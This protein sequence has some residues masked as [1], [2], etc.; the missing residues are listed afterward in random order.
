MK[1]QSIRPWSLLACG[2]LLVLAAC[3]Q[4]LPAEKQAYAG[5]WKANEM[6]LL[7]TADGGVKYERMT[8]SGSKSISAPLKAFEGDNFVVG[9]GPASTTFVVSAPPHADGDKTKMTVDGVELT[10]QAD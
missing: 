6:T 8:G 10:L 1:L 5:L 2:G 4:P 7:I 3:G 9:V